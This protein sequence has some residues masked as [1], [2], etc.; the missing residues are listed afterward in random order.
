MPASRRSSSNSAFQTPFSLHV[1][2]I[3]RNCETSSSDCSP[4]WSVESSR[5]RYFSDNSTITTLWFED[6][7]RVELREEEE[8]EQK[9]ILG[10][11]WI[12]S[13]SR[14]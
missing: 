13:S 4:S 7:L 1:R 10:I 5:R 9:G 8:R 12:F 2:L 6:D 14:A 11:C 3:G